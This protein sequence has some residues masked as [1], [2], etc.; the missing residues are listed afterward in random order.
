MSFTNFAALQSLTSVGNTDQFLVSLNNGLSGADGFG[1]V[2]TAAMN[3]SLGVYST[4][5]TNSAN[6]T[7]TLSFNA[8]NAQL[9]ISN[10][11]T[12]SLSALSAASGGA[13]IDT[14]VRA[15]TGN[16]Q[17][18]YTTV[19]S[20]SANWRST[21]STVS[22]NSAVW[23][24]GFTIFRQLSSTV[25]PNNTTS[26]HALSIISP[27]NDADFAIVSK[28]T[29][30]TLAQIPNS[31]VSGGNKRGLYATDWQ[32]IR[33]IATQV[34]SGNYSTIGGGAA[35][36]VSNEYSTVGGGGG[37]TSSSQYST[38]AGGYQNTANGQYASIGGGYL[39][40]A[41]A[42]YTTVAGGFQNNA[43]NTGAAV[44]GGFVNTVNSQYATIAGGYAN[45]ANDG[46]ASIGG[47]YAN[48]A[49][50]PYSTIPGGYGARTRLHGQ[51]SYASHYFTT[52]G[53][54]Q[55]F[56]YV[57]YGTAL[58]GNQVV[59][60]PNHVNY[61]TS[62]SSI[63][64]LFVPGQDMAAI[65]TIQVIGFDD[66]GNCSHSLTKLV[67]R[68]LAANSYNEELLVNTTIGT[69][70]TAAGTIT[71]AINTNTTPAHVFTVVGGSFGDNQTRWVAHVSGTWVYQPPVYP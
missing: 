33:N 32:K 19:S 67:V 66:S 49:A 35:N 13:G 25:S 54:G 50:G 8:S 17:S 31:G 36:T 65:L 11:N 47:G 59:L 40:A 52:N 29:G 45:T 44:G 10:G 3:K 51:Y 9:S 20:Q 62:N 57:L 14:G 41:S 27:L 28:G 16:W 55:H 69:D 68:K 53:D 60:S 70:G 46:F 71:F 4:V 30:A 7:Q 18:T 58:N 61:T 21:Y 23:N 56:Q 1:R 48:I 39:N 38:I 6:W 22:A 2:T 64:S 24:N 43:F 42:F 12:I 15:L 5:Q 26:V 63:P 37:N 34:A